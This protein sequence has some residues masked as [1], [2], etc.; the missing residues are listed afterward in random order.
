M[1]KDCSTCKSEKRTGKQQENSNHICW[2]NWSGSAKAMETEVAVTCCLQLLE[3]GVYLKW[4]IGDED[5]TT[6]SEIRKRVPHPYNQVEKLSDSNHLKK[7][8]TGRLYLLKATTYSKR[9]SGLSKAIIEHLGHNFAYAV[10]CNAGN[11][12]MICKALKN[13]LAH[14]FGDHSE[15]QSIGTTNWCKVWSEP[16]A[17]KPN[18]YKPNVYNQIYL[19]VNM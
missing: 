10:K 7:H 1:N 16:N 4:L 9:N 12:D 3:K 8:F 15:C 11:P 5:A 17:Y 6:I 19:D 14:S 2:K 18:A 13:L